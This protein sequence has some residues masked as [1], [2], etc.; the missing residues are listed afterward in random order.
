MA[1]INAVGNNLTDQTGTG[2]F[3]GDTSPTLITPNVDAI[4][5]TGDL[6]NQIVF[7][8]DTQSFE[9][10][11]SSRMDIS[12]TGFRLGAA[13]SRVT[14]ILDEDTMSSDSATALATQQSIKA[15]VDSKIPT[16]GA[17]LITPQLRLTLTSDDPFHDANVTAATSV[18]IDPCFGNIIPIY[19]GST[20]DLLTFTEIT[21]TVPSTTNTNYD[22]YAYN[23]SGSVNYELVA[24]SG[25]TTPSVNVA[26]LDGIWTKSTDS[27]RTYIGGFR[28]TGVSGQTEDSNSKRFVYNVYNQI[29]KNLYVQEG[30]ASWT[31]NTASFRQANNSTSNQVE[32]FNGI[33]LNCVDFEA[34]SQLHTSSTAAGGAVGI[35]ISSTTINSAILFDDIV[36]SSSDYINGKA[37]YTV[38][39]RG[40]YYI[41]WLEKGNAT[42]TNTWYGGNGSTGYQYGLRGTCWC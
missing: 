29:E 2:K 41:V 32:F 21:I 28:T 23:D 10:G 22:V 36:S 5:H 7:G 37:K 13:N 38:R 16:S 14:T 24:W 18:Y 1:N 12:D 34:T 6:D 17:S 8:T 15:Y 30:T 25:D 26:L 9:T 40:Y 35:G 33:G 3:A 42:G 20:W 19:N 31:Y 27:T 4:Q 39:K 11:G